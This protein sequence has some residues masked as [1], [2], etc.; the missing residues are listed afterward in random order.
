MTTGERVPKSPIRIEGPVPPTPLPFVQPGMGFTLDATLY[1]GILDQIDDGVYFVDRSKRILLWNHGAERIT[2]F[3]RGEIV[4]Q[5][6]GTRLLGHIDAGGRLL[7]TN[8]CPLERAVDSGVPI[9]AD[10]FLQHKLGHRVPVKIR[11]IPLRDQRNKLV[12]AVE[13]FRSTVDD[14]RQEQLIEELSQLAMIDDLTRLP[15]R[16]HFDVEL[17]R[18]LAELGRFGWPFGVLMIDIDHFKMVNDNAGHQV[19][20]E[21][22][23]LVARTL[24]ANCRSFDTVARWGGEEFTAIIANVREDELRLV[25]EKFRAMVEAS[26]L[27]D[28]IS[29]PIQITVSIGGALAQ[30]S[31]SAAELVKRADEMMY[32]AKRAGRNLVCI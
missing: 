24:S 28:D 31:E 1:H 20:D 21:I 32:A 15:N 10:A 6:C 26:G 11:T 8:G 9:E 30:A 4:G 3:L 5:S 25:A 22:L 16:R 23:R 17:D 18:R 14:R 2:G 19:G 7:C 12:G 29:A 27:R 13:I